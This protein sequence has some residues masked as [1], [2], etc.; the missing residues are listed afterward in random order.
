MIVYARGRV[1]A[2]PSAMTVLV[3]GEE[4]HSGQVGTGQPLDTECTFF[5]YDWGQPTPSGTV[6]SVSIVV[7]AGVVT[8]GPWF[9]NNPSGIPT[10]FGSD[11]RSEILINGS[12]PEWPATPVTPM[13]GGTPEDPDWYGWFFELGAGETMTFNIVAP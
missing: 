6:S 5:E 4:V 1:F 11:V 8:V 2:T 12:L 10:E 3:N 9:E 13:P 7:T